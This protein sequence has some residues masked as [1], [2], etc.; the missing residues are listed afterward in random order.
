MNFMAMNGGEFGC[1]STIHLL[2]LTSY[3]FYSIRRH[4]LPPEIQ[5]AFAILGWNETGWDESINPPSET[6][7]WV[8]LTPEMQDAASA[9]G[10]T[11]DSWDTEDESVDY[12]LTNSTQASSN[13]TAVIADENLTPDADYYEDYDWVELPSSVMEAAITLG[14]SQ[15]L[16]DSGGTAWSDE[17]FWDELPPDAQEAAAVFGY[18]E[19]TWNADGDTNL[20]SLLVAAGGQYISNDDDY[21]FEVGSSNIQVSEYQLLYLFAS[22]AFVFTGMIDL[23]REKKT[24]HLL[25]ILAGA[26]GVASAVFVEE[27]IHLSNILDCISVHLFLLEGMRLCNRLAVW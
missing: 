18:N 23:V 25:M 9:I 11:E 7:D 6:M 27:D 21:V 15:S 22:L 26:F 1:V 16:W 13:G 10:Y 8:E 3:T 2:P 24:F 17:L 12:D 5:A 4:D 20:E 19:V 14:W